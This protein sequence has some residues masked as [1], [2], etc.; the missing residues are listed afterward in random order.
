MQK[1]MEKDLSG[2]FTLPTNVIEL[3]EELNKLIEEGTLKGGLGG[4]VHPFP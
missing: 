4:L 2:T 3:S 1:M